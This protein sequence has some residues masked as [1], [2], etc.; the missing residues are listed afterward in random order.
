ME[1]MSLRDVL[2]VMCHEGTVLRRK[3]VEVLGI[4]L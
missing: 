1:F 3:G 4:L 2:S